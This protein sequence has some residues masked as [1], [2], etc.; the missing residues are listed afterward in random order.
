M[1]PIE[2][3][4]DDTLDIISDG[5]G[6]AARGPLVW[7]EEGKSLALHVAIMQNGGVAAM[8]HTGDDV[9]HGTVEFV[10]AA[11]VLGDGTLK[12]GPAIATGLALVR[13]EGPEMYQWSKAVTLKGAST[14]AKLKAK[15]K[16]DAKAHSAGLPETLSPEKRTQAHA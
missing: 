9:L 5:K 4:F 13:A 3:N 1:P 14:N 6:V 10:I 12:P 16:A 7:G 2:G 15:A 11:T 8:G